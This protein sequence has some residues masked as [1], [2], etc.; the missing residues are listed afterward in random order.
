MEPEIYREMKDIEDRHWWFLVH[1]KL[2]EKLISLKNGQ[3]LLDIG[4]GTG[5]ILSLFPSHKRVGIDIEPI[6]LKF[7]RKKKLKYIVQADALFLPFKKESFDYV[8]ILQVLYHKRAKNEEEILREAFRVLKIGGK[9][10]I[11]EPAFEFLRR[12]HDVVEHTRKRFVREELVKI[13]M[14]VGFRIDKSSYLYSYALPLILSLKF[15]R[16]K[17]EGSDLYLLPYPVNEFLKFL[18]YLEITFLP[19]FRIPFGSTI[20]VLAKK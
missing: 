15:L 2:V 12:G 16:L 5:R 3:L 6:A 18:G 13:I 1:Q 11:T 10:L 4:C 8:L 19:F 9:L 7:C 17:K 14:K 20:F